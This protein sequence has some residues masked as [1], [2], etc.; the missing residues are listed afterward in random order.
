MIAVEVLDRRE[1]VLPDVGYL[2]L[3]DAESGARRVVDTRDARVRDRFSK[4][5][6]YAVPTSLAT[7]PARVPTIS[8]SRPTTTGLSRRALLGPTPAAANCGGGPLMPDLTFLSPLRLWLLVLPLVIAGVYV[9]QQIRRRGYVL[10]FSDLSLFDEVAP[11]R[12]GWRRHLPAFVA[13]LALATIVLAFARPAVAEEHAKRDAVVV[14]ALD[15][16]LSMDATD[17]TPSRLDAAVDAAN[18]FLDEVPE[19]VRVGL[20]T[21]DGS[22]RVRALPAADIE[23]V[24]RVLSSLELDEG[25]AIGEGLYASLAAIGDAEGNET[26]ATETDDKDEDEDEDEAGAA[27]VLLS[28]GETTVGRANAEAADAAAAAGVRVHTV[29]FGTDAG[30]IEV[31]GMGEVSVPV[32]EQALAEVASATDGQAFTAE[33]AAALTSV[34]EDLGKRLTRTSEPREVADSFAGGALFLG[35]L[36]GAGSLKWFGRLP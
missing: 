36:A 8:E 3:V 18:A 25:T 13:V 10:R 33:T 24:R 19:G 2:T 7:S 27:V 11:D 4:R 30:T 15:T 32:N 35:L 31:P 16:S 20:V 29:A 26:E 21:F 6:L 22:A 34:Y 12:P 23:A 14:L 9:V 1:I 5:G 17:V 28:D